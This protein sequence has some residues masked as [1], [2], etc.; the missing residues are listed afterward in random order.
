MI[1]NVN[2]NKLAKYVV[3]NDGYW[4][5]RHPL[6]IVVNPILRKLQFLIDKPYV[7]ASILSDDLSEFKKFKFAKVKHIKNEK[8]FEFMNFLKRH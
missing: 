1:R 8:Y 5:H 3:H 4:C 6:K 7:I 2:P